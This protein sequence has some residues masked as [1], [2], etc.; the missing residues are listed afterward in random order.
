VLASIA[1]RGGR[2]FLV[3]GLIAFG[4]ERMESALRRNVDAIGWSLVA[5]CLVA[6]LMTRSWPA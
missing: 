6:W 5:A 2:F 1:G 3:A 4:G